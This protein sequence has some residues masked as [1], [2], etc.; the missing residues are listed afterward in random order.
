ME[1]KSS[2][3]IKK[4]AKDFS[5]YVCSSRGIPN[6]P[7]G[8]KDVQRK[9]LWGLKSKN[10][11]IKVNALVGHITEENLYVHG[12]AAG[13][14]AVSHMAAP[15]CNNIPFIYGD[16]N[17]GSRVSPTGWAAGRYTYVKKTK[18]T[19]SLLY[20][21]L[22][23]VPLKDN[24]DGSTKEPVHFLPLIPLT[25]L[26]G[27]SGI[28]VGWSTE[29]L[30]HSYK[31]IVQGCIDVLKGKKPK[32][33][34]PSYD[35]LD[36]EIEHI[37]DNTYYISGKVEIKD[38]STCIVRELSPYISIEK[39]KENLN[40]ME[41]NGII[42]SYTDNSTKS[43]NITVKF[44][45]GFLKD[46]TEKQIIDILKIKQ[47]KTERIVVIDF[48]GESIITYENPENLLVDFVNWRIEW[49]YK[50]YEKYIEDDSYELIYQKGLRKC[51]I[52]KL[53][54]KLKKLETKNELKEE[55]SKLT[56]NSLDERQTERLM[57]IPFYKW[58][59]DF[60][61]EVDEKIS[62]LEEK[63]KDDTDTMNNRKKLEQ[64]YISELENLKKLKV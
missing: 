51:I 47:K 59:V 11:K 63:I 7:D 56:D 13:M 62:K 18:I 6:L 28:A 58:T 46:K 36:V 35:Y 27:I 55:I 30:P 14:D 1:N 5:L 10:D 45:R 25:L 40:T 42:N 17:F 41:D 54:D 37:E 32:K 24:Y 44:P 8:L 15:Y 34:S 61:K 3:Y 49:F 2:D 9:I 60:I 33:L 4:I 12:D 43:I 29:I 38:T 39:F 26:N 48:N 57:S 22:A 19:E 21:D 16:G 64:I 31:D 50:R 53:P 52:G 20:T 23:I